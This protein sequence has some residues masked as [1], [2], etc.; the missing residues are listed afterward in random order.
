MKIT[1]V[2]ETY[3]PLIGGIPDHI[4][5]LSCELRKRGHKVKILTA[6]FSRGQEGDEDELVRVG[7]GMPI[8]ANKSFA[9]LTLGWRPSNKVKEFLR[10]YNPDIIHL[11][12]SLAPMLPVLA[13]R[14]SRTTNVATF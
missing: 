3:Y 8:R 10:D 13:L 12:G 1:M 14:H 5:H 2:S 7:L 6:K 4:F 9:R 11:H